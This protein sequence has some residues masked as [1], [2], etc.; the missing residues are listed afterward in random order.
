MSIKDK[1]EKGIYLLENIPRVMEMSGHEGIFINRNAPNLDEMDS[2]ENMN[3]PRDRI[4]THK[5]KAKS[6]GDWGLDIGIIN[7]KHFENREKLDEMLILDLRLTSKIPCQNIEQISFQKA[8][9]YLGVKVSTNMD[10]YLKNRNELEADL[11]R[12]VSDS[13]LKNQ[14]IYN[15]INQELFYKQMIKLFDKD[16]NG[17]AEDDLKTNVDNI[18]FE[19]AFFLKDFHKYLNGNYMYASAKRRDYYL[20][21]NFV[22]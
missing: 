17:A 8:L 13:D 21:F 19:K 20:I 6:Y 16:E 4:Q 14:H 5:L 12:K 18:F 11:L 22:F 10:F 3:W 9:E 15:K 7:T 2:L 1:L